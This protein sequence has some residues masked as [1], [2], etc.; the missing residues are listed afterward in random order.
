MASKEGRAVSVSTGEPR[1]VQSQAGLE[2]GNCN[3]VGGEAAQ[4][5]DA[6]FQARAMERRGSRVIP[7]ILVIQ[8]GE[9]GGTPWACQG[10]PLPCFLAGR[11]QP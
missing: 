8:P 1:G 10:P 11:L 6:S 5:K 4:R 7:C 3:S 2:D 9:Q